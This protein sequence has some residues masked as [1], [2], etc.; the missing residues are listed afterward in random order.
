MTEVTECVICMSSP[1]VLDERLTCSHNK[2]FCKECIDQCI[3][4]ELYTC[5]SCRTKFDIDLPVHITIND[6]GEIRHLPTWSDMIT[7]YLISVVVHFI[8]IMWLF[9]ILVSFINLCTAIVT[10][11]SN[12]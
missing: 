9:G 2:D 4:K 6:T 7:Q 10:M 11:D 8:L 3:E 12:I 5:P 1:P